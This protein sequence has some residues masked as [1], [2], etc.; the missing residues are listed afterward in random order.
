MEK[1]YSNN[2]CNVDLG[3]GKSWRE[4]MVTLYTANSSGEAVMPVECERDDWRACP[5]HKHLTP[6]PTP[7]ATTLPSTDND[8]TSAVTFEQ[9]GGQ[10]NEPK[11]WSIEI[12]TI[13]KKTGAI[14][15]KEKL[16]GFNNRFEAE[17]QILQDYN[18]K[19]VNIK[20]GHLES[21]YGMFET[22]D[23]YY[24]RVRNNLGLI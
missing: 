7:T 18:P 1:L 11:T 5:Q 6:L 12:I 15:S 19:N 3:L 21:P 10:S 9:Y 8:A 16:H 17:D 4:K 14:I 24:Y 13:N 2:T 20:I 23:P 22:L